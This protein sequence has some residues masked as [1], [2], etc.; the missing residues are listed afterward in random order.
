MDADQKRTLHNHNTVSKMCPRII[1]QMIVLMF[2]RF[3][4]IY[5][6]NDVFLSDGSILTSQK[7]QW[8]RTK[9][10]YILPTVNKQGHESK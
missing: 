3:I 4:Y 6:K 2:F 5:T 1:Y 9:D 8:E 7:E 10:D